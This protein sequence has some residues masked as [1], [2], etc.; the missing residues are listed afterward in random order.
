MD[1][2]VL[3]AK[4]VYTISI[5]QGEMVKTKINCILLCLMRL[6]KLAI[7]K[8]RKFSIKF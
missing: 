8:Y 1:D 3:E 4:F 5:I 7:H 2:K 6:E